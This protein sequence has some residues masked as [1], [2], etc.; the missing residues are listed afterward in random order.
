[1]SP[2]SH[3]KDNVPTQGNANL[4]ERY[5]VDYLGHSQYSASNLSQVPGAGSCRYGGPGL[6]DVL[7]WGRECV[8]V[9]NESFLACK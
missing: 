5:Q 7:E 6:T 4:L 2:I 9:S 3:V 1:M 8:L